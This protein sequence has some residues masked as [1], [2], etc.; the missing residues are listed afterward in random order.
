MKLYSYWRSSCSWRVR[1]ALAY[2]KQTYEYRAVHLVQDGGHQHKIEHIQKNPMR[3][4]PSLVLDDGTV[5]NQSLAIIQFLESIVPSPNLLGTTSKEQAR[6][7]ELS[8]IINAGTQPL[9]NLSVLQHVQREHDLDKINWGR[10]FITIGLDALEARTKP[11]SYKFC[12]RDE[13][14][15][16]DLCLIPQLYNARRFSCDMERWPTL[17]EIESRCEQIPEFIQ[18]HPSQQPDAVL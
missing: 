1:I 16:A 10:H 7:W 17:L 3:Q 13:V 11:F 15:L 18:A 2:K 14:S 6:V 8:E 12:A 5:L 4:V 9:Q